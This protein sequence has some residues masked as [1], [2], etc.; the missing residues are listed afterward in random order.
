[1]GCFHTC[2]CCVLELWFVLDV[3]MSTCQRYNNVALQ[4][5]KEL[6]VSVCSPCQNVQ[7]GSLGVVVSFPVEEKQMRQAICIFV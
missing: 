2:F 6:L 5:T 7:I 4:S 3:K 1:M